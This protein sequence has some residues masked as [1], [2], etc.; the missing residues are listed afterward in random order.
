MENHAEGGV[1]VDAKVRPG[2]KLVDIKVKSYYDTET[3][4]RVIQLMVMFAPSS[5]IKEVE[6]GRIEI[7]CDKIISNILPLSGYCDIE[8][9][10]NGL[11]E[12]AK[13]LDA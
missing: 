7:P 11:I 2:R 8:D 12:M 9:V 5:A 13:A 1:R 3:N 10:T 4:N 6:P